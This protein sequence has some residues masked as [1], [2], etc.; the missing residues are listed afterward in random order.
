MKCTLAY[1]ELTSTE[2]YKS[3]SSSIQI[4]SEG[5]SKAMT[6][7]TTA[8]IFCRRMEV[9]MHEGKTMVRQFNSQIASVAF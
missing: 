2:H 9:E 6:H 8:P 3:F 5:E 4:Q 7:K 1:I